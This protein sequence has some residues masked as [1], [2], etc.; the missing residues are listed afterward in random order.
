MF[1]KKDPLIEQAKPN[2]LMIDSSP[3]ELFVK[4][5]LKTNCYLL[6]SNYRFK[7]FRINLNTA[8]LKDNDE[9]QGHL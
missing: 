5:L 1:N 2:S 8:W 7:L 6:K 4:T 3:K 9:T